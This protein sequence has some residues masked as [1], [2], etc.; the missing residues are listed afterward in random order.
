MVTRIRP[1]M[2][3][4]SS[5]TEKVELKHNFIQVTENTKTCISVSEILNTFRLHKMIS[6]SLVTLISPVP[7]QIHT[8]NDCNHD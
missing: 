2:Y 8:V 4:D 7:E 3:K 1:L 6:R 5:H